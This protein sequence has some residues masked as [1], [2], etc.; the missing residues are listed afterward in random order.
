MLS[1][2]ISGG[3]TGADQGGWRAAKGAG[4]QT[5][6][7]MPRGFMTEDG[8]RPEFA[9]MYGA[10]AHQSASYRDRTMANAMEADGTL[11]FN[12]GSTFSP[13]TLL[14]MGCCGESGRPF[15]IVVIHRQRWKPSLDPDDVVSWMRQFHVATLNVAGNRESKA[16]GIGRW[17]E[18]YLGKVF[19]V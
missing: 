3:Q 13:G 9:D 4:L 15:L 1:K 12:H 10:R 16:R 14:A 8:P 2:V 6:G 7:W 17:A 11:I 18:G 5:A 19:A